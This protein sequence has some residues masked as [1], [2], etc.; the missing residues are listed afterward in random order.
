MIHF[1]M[2]SE[3]IEALLAMGEYTG[4]EDAFLRESA[5]RIQGVSKCSQEEAK[6]ILQDLRNHGGIDFEITPEG[7]L[8]VPPT[9]IPVACWH[10]YLRS[11][12]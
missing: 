6:R 4:A 9:G 5:A 8:P 3:A 11:A 12:A 1:G 7:E 2:Y 10:W